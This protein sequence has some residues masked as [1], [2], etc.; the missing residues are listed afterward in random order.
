MF[1]IMG[2]TWD[3][4][5]MYAGVVSGGALTNV[6][7]ACGVFNKTSCMTFNEA[8]VATPSGYAIVSGLWPRGVP[9]LAHTILG[10]GHTF[11]RFCKTCPQQPVKT[12]T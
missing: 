1:Y 9:C 11:D 5:M 4:I 7:E 3:G 10:Y 8:Q 12:G 6:F 2:V